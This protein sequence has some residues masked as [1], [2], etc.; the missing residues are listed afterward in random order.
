MS[1]T[2][3]SAV[4]PSQTQKD[5]LTYIPDWQ[6]KKRQHLLS[7]NS[8]DLDRYLRRDVEDELLLGPLKYWM[9]HADDMWK[10]DLSKMAID[11]FCIPAM[12][13]DPERL[14]SRYLFTSFLPL[15]FTNF[16]YL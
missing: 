7:D 12:S 1:S 13:T 9:D 6:R 15:E 5:S 14:F 8:D 11:I 4:F 16:V 3:S 10:R 2:I